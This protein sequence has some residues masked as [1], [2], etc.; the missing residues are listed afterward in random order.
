MALLTALALL[1]GSLALVLALSTSAAAATRHGSF[2]ATPS[3]GTVAAGLA[4]VTADGPCPAPAPADEPY[5]RGVLVLVDPGDP[6][7]TAPIAEVVPGGP[8]G[9]V[10]LSGAPVAGAGHA[11][12]QDR[13][14]ELVPSGPLD[15]RYELRLACETATSEARAAYFSLMIEVTGENWAAVD[16]QATHLVVTADPAQPPVGLPFTVKA[17][18][19]PATAAGTVA[20]FTLVND[21]ITELG[22]KDLVDGTAE[23]AV[24]MHDTLTAPMPVLAQFTPADPA[25]YT[26]A[27]QVAEFYPVPVPTG[28]P[29][30]TPTPTQTTGPTPTD[31]PS[32][33]PT[34]DPTDDPTG[35]PTPTDTAGTPTATGTATP[36]ATGTGDTSGTGTGGGSGSGSGSGDTSS[37]TGPGSASGTGSGSGAS[38]QGGSGGTLAATGAASAASAALGALALC[39]LGAATVLTVRRRGA[40]ARP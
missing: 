9:T 17:A 34:D 3:S 14:R 7:L 11:T 30:P 6:A 1:C 19:Q 13:L 26:P 23:L 16:Q 22:T 24:T 33:T 12:L 20:F 21:E 37:G 40:G 38:P 39:L 31:T 18:V 32:G 2:A 4:S 36:T 8:L 28:T 29:T 10:P 15:G 25:A 35:E 5:T 27:Q